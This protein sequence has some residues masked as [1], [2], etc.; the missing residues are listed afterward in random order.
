MI[1]NAPLGIIYLFPLLPLSPFSCPSLPPLLPSGSEALTPAPP[2]T[3]IPQALK[4]LSIKRTTDADRHEFYG[5]AEA[6][7]AYICMDLISIDGEAGAR[8]AS[9]G[10]WDLLYMVM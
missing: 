5:H 1:N 4:H 2:P 10:G 8:D 9:R 7:A 3:L 6:F